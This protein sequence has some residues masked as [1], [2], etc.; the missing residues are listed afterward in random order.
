M[1]KFDRAIFIFIGLGIWAFVLTQFLTPSSSVVAHGW[2][3]PADH[4]HDATLG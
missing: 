3:A 4:E 2:N 1:S